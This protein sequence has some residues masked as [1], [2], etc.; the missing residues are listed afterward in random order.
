MFYPG[1]LLIS[2]E[3]V[4]N[5]YP[6]ACPQRRQSW[7]YVAKSVGP[8]HLKVALVNPQVLDPQNL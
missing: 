8:W 7:A 5:F 1:L 6:R 3:L 2:S 4:L